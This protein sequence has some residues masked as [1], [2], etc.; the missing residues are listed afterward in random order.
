MAKFGIFLK[1]QDITALL[2]NCR[3]SYDEIDLIRM[4]HTLRTEIP[5]D[6]IKTLNL[7]FDKISEG[8]SSMDVEEALLYLNVRQHP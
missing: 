1:S 8:Q 2:N 4:A 5:T 6:I 7:I 3:H